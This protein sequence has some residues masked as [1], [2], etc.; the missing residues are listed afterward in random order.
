MMNAMQPA[1]TPQRPMDADLDVAGP[2]WLVQ[3]SWPGRRWLVQLAGRAVTL[4]DASGEPV[5]EPALAALLAGSL[6]ADAAVLDGVLTSMPL[7]GGAGTED[8]GGAEIGAG[9]EG[10][11][12]TEG[13]AEGVLPGGVGA[14]VA[15]DLLEVDGQSLL[16]IPFQERHR[17]LQSV[18]RPGPRVAVSPVVGAP[19]HGWLGAWRQNGFTHVVAR[20][21][22]ARYRPGERSDDCLRLPIP[23]ATAP[24][25]SLLERLVGTRQRR[26]RIGG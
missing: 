24:A 16:D 2:E 17:L 13:G 20:H 22:N 15:V 8:G 19:F 14:F 7:E 11:T 25:P 5:D 9:T 18:V 3:P 4:L 21:R 10:G 6:A 1:L 23:L 12:R 26:P